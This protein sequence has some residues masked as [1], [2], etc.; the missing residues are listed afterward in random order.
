MDKMSLYYVLSRFNHIR[1]RFLYLITVKTNTQNKK[2]YIMCPLAMYQITNTF[3]VDRIIY[4]AIII[5]HYDTTNFK[6]LMCI[7]MGNNLGIMMG[8]MHQ[9]ENN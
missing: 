4:H 7:M 8:N 3:Q 6:R 1:S 5:F 2:K 9:F